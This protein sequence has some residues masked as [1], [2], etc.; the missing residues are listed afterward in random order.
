[1]QATIVQPVRLPSIPIAA[2]III[3][4]LRNEF[5]EELKTPSPVIFSFLLLSFGPF[6]LCGKQVNLAKALK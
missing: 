5:R 2:G 4:I 6:R 3:C 1:M